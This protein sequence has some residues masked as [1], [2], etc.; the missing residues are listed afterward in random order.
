MPVSRFLFFEDSDAA[1]LT[2]F[3]EAV[4]RPAA[5]LQDRYRTRVWRS[6]ALAGQWVRLDFGAAVPCDMLALVSHNLTG[7][8]QVT[9]KAGTSAGDDSL[10]S[11]TFDGHDP[12]FGTDDVGNDEMTAGGYPLPG[13]ETDWWPN[14]PVQCIYLPAAVEARY[15]EIR[16]DDPDNPDGYIEMGRLGLGFKIEAPRGPAEIK[17]SGPKY[18]SVISRALSGAPH[19]DPKQ[20][21]LYLDLN[22]AL[23][24]RTVLWSV[25]DR[26]RQ[27]M[28][29]GRAFVAD[30]FADTDLLPLRN[31]GK[32]YSLVESDEDGIN[33]V[34]GLLGAYNL[35]LWEW[36]G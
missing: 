27:R 34:P 33:V 24:D 13:Y 35:K 5:N 8:S 10:Y 4:T 28:A 22:F 12:I 6:T 25:W 19:V 11:G 15:W 1:T 23:I 16:F 31:K 18:P 17:D 9:I 20:P 21:Y 26:L 3:T 2:A 30:V 36:V 14:G 7:G 29:A 32:M